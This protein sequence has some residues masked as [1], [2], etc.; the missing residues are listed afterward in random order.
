MGS[1]RAKVDSTRPLKFYAQNWHSNTSVSLYWSKE[2]TS[3]AQSPA[4]EEG[5]WLHTFW[6]KKWRVLTGHGGIING[7]SL[8]SSAATSH[9]LL[10]IRMSLDQNI[11]SN[12]TD[13]T[14]SWPE[15]GKGFKGS[16]PCFPA[17]RGRDWRNT[18]WLK[19]YSMIQPSL[20][21]QIIC[22]YKLFT[23]SYQ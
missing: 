15:Q 16:F 23:R 6:C 22:F 21:F 11:Y 18:A 17:K 10:E 3:P 13:F 19:K 5:K 2:V 14:D 9:P 20:L 7:P 12:N 4:Q 8:Q 1:K